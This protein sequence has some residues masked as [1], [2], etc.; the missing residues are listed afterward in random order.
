MVAL[1][2]PEKSAFMVSKTTRFAPMESMAFPQMDEQSLQVI[3]TRPFNLASL[4][5]DVVRCDETTRHHVMEIKTKEFFYF[6]DS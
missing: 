1:D 6:L 4:D 2:G 3:L 5:V